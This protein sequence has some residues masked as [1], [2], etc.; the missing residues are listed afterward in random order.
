MT[1]PTI[2][3]EPVTNF[4]VVSQCVLSELGLKDQLARS[5]LDS[6]SLDPMLLG[7]LW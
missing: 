7:Y 3:S 1:H 4:S 2:L 5:L 6:R